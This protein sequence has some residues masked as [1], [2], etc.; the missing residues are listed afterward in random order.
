MKKSLLVFILL[1]CVYFML[2]SSSSGVT[3]GQMADMTNSPVS[4]GSCA[5]CHVGGSFESSMSIQLLNAAD[6]PVTSYSPGESY[7]IKYVIN[8]TGA[9]R[10]GIQST[11]LKSDNGAAGVLTANSSNVKISTLSSRSYVD[12]KAP[13]STNE[14]LVNWVA[15]AAGTGTV[16]IYSNALAAN[17]TGSTDGD[18]LVSTA[19]VEITEGFSASILKKE[20]DKA[21]LYPNPATQFIRF[22]GEE[23]PESM[24]VFT[25]SG[26]SVL[27]QFSGSELDIRQLTPG[28]YLVKVK[29]GDNTLVSRFQ[30]SE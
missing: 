27:K 6:Q 12:H 16:K 10:Y 7:K 25:L 3:S 13:S 18:K 9:S 23:I 1:S 2:Q 20:S 14:F 11:V 5:N 26:K 19:A 15:P 4:S 29:T 22:S 28:M 17:G 8:A 21:V 30:K 24:E